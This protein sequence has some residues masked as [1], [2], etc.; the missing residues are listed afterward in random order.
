M[1]KLKD[2]NVGDDEMI[3]Q[4]ISMLGMDRRILSELAR[5]NGRSLSAEI[6][7]RVRQ[8]MKNECVVA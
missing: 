4:T 6:M 7:Y 8:T 5:E 3:T 1:A 2:R